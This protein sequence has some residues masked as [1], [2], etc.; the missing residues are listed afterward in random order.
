MF[1]FVSQQIL[2]TFASV[3][4]PLANLTEISVWEIGFRVG[5]ERHDVQEPLV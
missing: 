5:P 4:K 2:T 1:G 3:A